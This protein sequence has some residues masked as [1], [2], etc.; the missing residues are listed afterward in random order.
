MNEQARNAEGARKGG[1]EHSSPQESERKL[2]GDHQCN[3]YLQLIFVT[4]F[5]KEDTIKSL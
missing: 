2:R 3:E 5:A 1:I 4:D